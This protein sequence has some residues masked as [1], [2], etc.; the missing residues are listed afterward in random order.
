F[1]FVHRLDYATSGVL[2]VA[3]NKPACSAAT[4]AFEKRK[5]KKY[6]I[7]LLRG[8][9]AGEIL[10]VTVPIGEAASETSGS[11]MMCTNTGSNEC[12]SAR[13]AHSRLLVIGR[14]MYGGYPATKV[15]LRPVTGR[16]HQLRVHC[17]HIGHTIVGDFTYSR[18]KDV[19]PHR[20][21]LHAFR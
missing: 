5:A 17:T 20:T 11:H 8:H 12:L 4:T 19:Q 21:F 7:A 3:L 10:D 13:W 14:G 15:L 18:R 1:Y 16:R 2:C 9:V 6:Y